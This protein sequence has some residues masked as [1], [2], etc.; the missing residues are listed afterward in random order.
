VLHSPPGPFRSPRQPKEPQSCRR[1][2]PTRSAATPAHW[3]CCDTCGYS[4][5]QLEV[6]LVITLHH[7]LQHLP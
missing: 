4:N 6:L 5:L 7:L 1:L 2:T 3:Q